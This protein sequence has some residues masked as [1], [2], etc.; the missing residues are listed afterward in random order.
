MQVQNY[1]LKVLTRVS[2]F[3]FLKILLEQVKNFYILEIPSVEQAGCQHECSK[4][5][6]SRSAFCFWS[7]ENV[8]TQNE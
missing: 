3:Q 6:K 4:A 7:L 8:K 1:L 5:L 2:K